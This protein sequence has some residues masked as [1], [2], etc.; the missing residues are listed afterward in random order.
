M[1]DHHTAYIL[2]CPERGYYAGLYS[3][4]DKE[5][6]REWVGT[7]EDASVYEGFGYTCEEARNLVGEGETMHVVRIFFTYKDIVHSDIAAIVYG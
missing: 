5:H 7:R 4:E 1:K 6:H 2:F 3:E